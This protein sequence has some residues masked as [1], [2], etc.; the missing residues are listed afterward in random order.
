MRSSPHTTRQAAICLR[1]TSGIAGQILPEYAGVWVA[2]GREPEFSCASTLHGH[3][4]KP[5]RAGSQFRHRHRCGAQ[6]CGQRG[7]RNARRLCGRIG[8]AQSPA[9]HPGRV[10]GL[11]RA[12]G[13]RHQQ[14]GQIGGWHPVWGTDWLRPCRGRHGVGARHGNRSGRGRGG[15]VEREQPFDD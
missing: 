3:C 6:P 10:V 11:P 14:C 13:R 1:Q 5:H 8:R 15:L 2:M 7:H 9:A 4:K 12:H